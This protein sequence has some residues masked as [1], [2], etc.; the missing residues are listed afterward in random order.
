MEM[1][2]GVTLLVTYKAWSRWLG[3]V[4]KER[5]SRM[6]RSFFSSIITIISFNHQLRI[7]S[8]PQIFKTSK[9]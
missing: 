8:I 4:Y 9:I 2:K 1:D 3:D 5:V 6:V 7:Q